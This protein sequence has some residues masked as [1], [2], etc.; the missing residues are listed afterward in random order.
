MTHNGFRV[1]LDALRDAEDGIRAAVSELGDMAGWSAAGEQGMGLE[2]SL[3]DAAVRVG[4]P[5]LGGALVAFGDAWHWGLRYLV[6]DGQAAVDALGEA[7]TTYREVDDQAAHEL[8]RGAG[9]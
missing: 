2:E 7:R 8:Q 4:H 1:D 9:G 3:S 5:R 6:E